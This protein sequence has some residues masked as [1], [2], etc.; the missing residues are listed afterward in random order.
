M[1]ICTAGLKR[2]NYMGYANFGGE[3]VTLNEV[4]RGDTPSE[5]GGVS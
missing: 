3:G 5:E 2:S 4:V 1:M